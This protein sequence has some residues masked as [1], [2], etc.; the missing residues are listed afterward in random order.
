MN[1]EIKKLE[2]EGEII[3]AIDLA[4]EVFMKFEAP[5]YPKE[6]TNSFLG[7]LYGENMRRMLLEKSIVFFGAF[8]ENQLIGMC[9]V[10]DKNHISLFF[11]RESCQR[12]GVGRKLFYTISNFAKENYNSKT[13]TVNSSPFGLPFYSAM[14]FIPTDMER[15]EDGI[16]Y[17]PMINVSSPAKA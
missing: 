15:I 11:V 14:G 7:F 4:K 5:I 6:G 8:E 16:T 1:F 10:R 12:R 17:T 3:C 13:F 9:A 2:T